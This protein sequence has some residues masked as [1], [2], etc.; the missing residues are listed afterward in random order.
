[1]KSILFAVLFASF[2]LAACTTPLVTGRDIETEPVSQTFN[3]PAIASFEAAEKALRDMDYNVEYANK[4]EG[5][6]RTGWQPT[7]ID[8]H[9]LEVFG[10][11]DYGANGAYYYM[12][13]RITADGP[14]MSTVQV[15]APLR[16]IVSRMWSTHRQEKKFLAKVRNMLLPGDMQITNI[17]VVE[18]RV[19]PVRD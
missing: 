14:N 9:Y 17:G 5:V 2:G 19:V 13:V 8:S 6:L 4:D 16:T 18:P 7:T 11:P 3:A 1:M 10:R 12:M 15:S